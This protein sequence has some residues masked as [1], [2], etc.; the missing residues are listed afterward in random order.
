MSAIEP[1]RQ[2]PSGECTGVRWPWLSL[3][4][5]A[6]LAAYSVLLL[7]FRGLPYL[8]LPNHVARASVLAQI[9]MGQHTAYTAHYV[10]QPAPVPYFLPD[11]LLTLL[12]SIAGPSAGGAIWA[13]VAFVSLPAS[14]LFVA[15]V[16]GMARLASALAVLF[17][18]SVSVDWAFLAGFFAYR[19]GIA[20]ALVAVALFMRCLQD[21]SVGRYLLF[22]AVCLVCYL[23]HLSSP[24]MACTAIAAVSAL[25]L[26]RGRMR[27]ATALLYLAPPAA[28]LVWNSLVAPALGVGP[29]EW[30]T[31]AEKLRRLIGP[32][33]RYNDLLDAIILAGLLG[34]LVCAAAAW[35]R[36]NLWRASELAAASL[37]FVVLY[38]VLPHG[39][40]E[41][42]EIDIRAV[43]L[44]WLFGGLAALAALDASKKTALSVGAA[45]AS[46]GMLNLAYMGTYL[47]QIDTA[48]VAY[49]AVALQV[50]PG[51]QVLPIVTR[52]SVGRTPAFLH[53]GAF[54]IERGAFEPYL[55][56][57]DLGT[58]ITYF[59]QRERFY[60]PSINWW[61][62]ET[63]RVDWGAVAQQY[64]YL[65]VQKP[66]DAARIQVRTSAVAEND[67]AALLRI[68]K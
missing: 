48:L 45:L 56:S 61:F 23:T 27:A 20:T 52:K 15:R 42:Y 46:V 57:R 63:R 41:I 13:F 68:L 39:K 44:A 35:T 43:P 18:I 24:L 12:V 47:R 7:S 30:A 3:V 65:I 9:L 22:V 59:W 49:R 54:V 60:T 17:A 67:A 62:D 33:G 6:L 58:P 64:Q 29:T 19:L 32:F 5:A 21:W 14:V 31:P 51:A 11:C 66:Y 38:A 26:V 10:F 36:A 40:G 53:A 28:A 2:L 34:A 55:F 37:G 25:R 1:A 16:W 8:D 50:P 4:A